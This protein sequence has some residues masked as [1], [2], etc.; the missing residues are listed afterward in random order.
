MK[1]RKSTQKLSRDTNQRKAL[2]RGL[3]VALIQH[4]EIK[5]TKAKAKAIRSLVEKLITKGK[6]GTLHATRLI[7]SMIQDKEATQKIVKDI[8]PR[9]KNVKGGYTKVTRIENRRG[10]NAA[11]VVLELSKKKEEEKV[12]KKPTKKKKPAKKESSKEKN[13]AKA[14]S[15]KAVSIKPKDVEMK[16][17]KSDTSTPTPLPKKGLGSRGK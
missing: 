1:K 8:A 12:G 5:T 15:K 7:Q 9:F 10:D 3:I 4:E 11:M 6:S 16:S 17:E 2:F 13:K 14:E